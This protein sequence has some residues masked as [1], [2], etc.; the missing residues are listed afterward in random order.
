MTWC[1]W[2]KPHVKVLI[3][4]IVKIFL[5]W[6]GFCIDSKTDRDSAIDA[7]SICENKVVSKFGSDY[8]V[9]RFENLETSEMWTAC[10]SCVTVWY[11]FGSSHDMQCLIWAERRRSSK[12]QANRCLRQLVESSSN[13]FTA[14]RNTRNRVEKLIDESRNLVLRWRP[15]TWEEP[16]QF[17]VPL[18]FK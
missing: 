18:V 9:A 14:L 15:R 13:W 10:E 7:V 12:R 17:K 16:S 1:R 2:E 11:H 4:Q 5:N 8:A 6:V 3:M